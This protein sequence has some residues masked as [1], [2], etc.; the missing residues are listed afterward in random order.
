VDVERAG[1]DGTCGVARRL[2]IIE[3]VVLIDGRNANDPRK[4]ATACFTQ[5]AKTWS[6][7]GGEE[8][9]CA[10]ARRWQAHIPSHLRLVLIATCH[11]RQTMEEQPYTLARWRV[12]EGQEDAVVAAWHLLAA[13]FLMLK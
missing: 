12:R 4:R 1:W 9:P 7:M 13:F 10:Q 6:P 8:R 3:R 2:I 5:A 11:R